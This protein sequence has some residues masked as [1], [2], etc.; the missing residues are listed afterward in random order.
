M[1]NSFIVFLNQYFMKFANI[2]TIDKLKYNPIFNVSED[3]NIIDDNVPTLII[4][5]DLVKKKYGDDFSVIK[6][7]LSDKIFWT[8]SKM[9]RRYE[10]ENDLSEFLNFVIDFYSNKIKYIF[11][12]IVLARYSRIKSFINYIKNK[13]KIIFIHNNSHIFIYE[14]DTDYVVGFSLDDCSYFNVTKERI[15]NFIKSFK[16]NHVY[17]ENYSYSLNRIVGNKKHLIPYFLQ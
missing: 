15:I 11:F 9:E 3:I 2:I 14:K 13:D 5:Y 7:K 8:F 1:I 12:N 6:R 4:G 10:Y 16:C 17:D